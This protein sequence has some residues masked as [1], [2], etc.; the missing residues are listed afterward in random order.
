LV[1]RM[2]FKRFF[3]TPL[4]AVLLLFGLALPLAA[5]TYFVDKN[6]NRA[7]DSTSG[8]RENPWYSIQH[9]L[10]QLQPGDTLFIREGIYTNPLRMSNSGLTD[11]AIVIQAFPGDEVIIDGSSST[12]DKF[13]DWKGSASNGV[14]K[15]HIV[16][17]GFT[18]RNVP[19]WGI[20]IEGDHNVIQNCI[21]YNCGVSTK[22]VGILIRQGDR[23]IIRRNEVSNC[24]WNGI[25]AENSNY[26]LIEYNISR[27]NVLHFGINIFPNTSD[28]QDM[29]T[30]NRIRNNTLYNN[31]GGIYTRYQKRYDISG[32]LIFNNQENGIFLHRHHEGPAT[33][34]ADGRI[35][36]NT[37]VNNGFSGIRNNSATHLIILNNI[38][39]GHTVQNSQYEIFMNSGATSGHQL[40]HNVYFPDVDNIVYWGGSKY[41]FSEMRSVRGQESSGRAVDPEFL[42]LQ[43]QDFRLKSNSGAINMGVDVGSF[44][45]WRDIMGV[46]RPHDGQFDAGALEFIMLD[47]T[48]PSPPGSFTIENGN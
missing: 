2:K 18:I 28:T 36:N 48:A 14:D 45:V 34:R 40:N 11:K 35:L 26:T 37:I 30:G 20:W 1:T 29:Q 7:S 13:I 47:T 12:R 8:T 31:L 6:H 4:P 32:N 9:G 10:N 15:H 43:T 27:D 17:D 5:E 41:N 19:R 21:I 3:L 33:Y 39:Y 38:I 22:G 23:N 46:I 44:G 24:G 25:N 16:L 42:D